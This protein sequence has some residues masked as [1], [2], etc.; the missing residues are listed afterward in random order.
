MVMGCP[1]GT[2]GPRSIVKT[3]LGPSGYVASPHEPPD[4][5]SGDVTVMGTLADAPAAPVSEAAKGSRLAQM[6]LKV[7]VAVC[8]GVGVMEAVAVIVGDGVAPCVSV[9]VMDAVA[10][11]DGVMVDDSEGSTVKSTDALGVAVYDAEAVIEAVGVGVAPPDSVE[12]G[13]VLGVSD[14][15]GVMVGCV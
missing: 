4:H 6:G 2:S 12:V 11:E 5:S 1:I 9:D 15:V 13:V 8:V 7:G 3:A 10:D 14:D